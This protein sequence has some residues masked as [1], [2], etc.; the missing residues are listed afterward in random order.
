MKDNIE[1]LFQMSIDCMDDAQILFEKQRFVGTANRAYYAYFDAIRTLLAT[2]EI[3][4]KS[5]SGT[6]AKFAEIFVKTG[7]LPTHTSKNLRILY[8]FRQGGDYD[9]DIEITEA[10]AKYCLDTTQDFIT[11]TEN[12]LKIQ[13]FL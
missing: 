4:G 7:V 3:W 13:G 1:N 5:H 12:Y 10:D 9:T 6:H 2:K 11:L 8:E